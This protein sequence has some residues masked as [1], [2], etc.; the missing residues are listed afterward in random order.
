MPKRILV[1]SNTAFSIRKFRKELIFSLIEKGYEVILSLPEKDEALENELA[2]K[3]IEI[4]YRRR[5]KNVFQDLL[6]IKHFY[7]LFKQVNPD[8]I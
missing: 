7:T 1:L 4:P 8:L 3:I 2:C 5:S 6:L